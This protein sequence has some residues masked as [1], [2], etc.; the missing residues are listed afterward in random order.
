MK[1]LWRVLLAALA[2]AAG[3]AVVGALGVYVLSEHIIHR[4]YDAPLVDI[5][6]PTDAESIHEGE[7]LAR[8]RGCN[9]GCHGARVGGALWDEGTWQGQ[10]MAPD[11]ALAARTL[12]TSQFERVV[13]QGIRA[14]GEGVLIMPASMFHF[15]NDADFG[16]IL[17]FLRAEPVTDGRV[18]ALTPAPNWRWL[19][20]RGEWVPIPVELERMSPAMRRPIPPDAEH[21]GEYLARTSCPECHGAALEGDGVSTPN[22]AIVRAYSEEAFTSFMRTGKALGNRELELMSD[23]ARERFSHFTAAEVHALYTY[24]HRE[25]TEEATAGT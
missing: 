6:V 17:A 21:L 14:N 3:C 18:Y 13:R 1:R 20:V 15:L 11:I 8:I 23:T 19:L 2:V 16:R 25:R 4:K 9:G 12:S 7:R 5:A 22:L 10:A 24:L